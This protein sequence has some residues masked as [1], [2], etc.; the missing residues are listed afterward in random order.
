M[1]VII[2]VSSV[3]V[4]WVINFR[5]AALYIYIHSYM[6]VDR[7]PTVKTTAIVP[8][9]TSRSHVTTVA[10]HPKFVW[11]LTPTTMLK[12]F[13]ITMYLQLFNTNFLF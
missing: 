12:T 4:G 6:T 13:I 1:Q 10:A 5:C 2:N 9:L 3:V 8:P 11:F 7:F